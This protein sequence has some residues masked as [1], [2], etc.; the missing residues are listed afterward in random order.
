[1]DISVIEDNYGHRNNY[2]IFNQ[3]NNWGKVHDEFEG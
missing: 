2:S 1:M 3:Y